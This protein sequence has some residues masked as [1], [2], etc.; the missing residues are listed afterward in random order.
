M[1]PVWLFFL[2]SQVSMW[3]TIVQNSY[4]T[5]VL[6]GWNKFRQVGRSQGVGSHDRV[7]SSSDAQAMLSADSTLANGTKSFSVTLESVGSQTIMATDTVATA[8]TGSS[9]SIEVST[10]TNL[11]GFHATG[12]MGTERAAHTATLLQNGK[13]LIAGGFNNTDV[14]ATAELFDPATGTFTPTGA[15][16]TPRFSHTAT[17]LANGKVLVTGGS[18]NLGDLATHNSR[19]VNLLANGKVLV[20]GGS[21]NSGDLATAEL[22]DPATGTFTATG[23]MSEPR[24]EHTATL[25]ANGTVL[26]AGGAAGNAAE[27]FDPAT[28]SFTAT[29]ELT[30]GGRWG[31]TATLLK[32]GT[33]LIAGGRDSEDV[34]DAFP[35][36]DAELFNPAT[37]TFTATG[38]MTQFRYEHAAALLN[39]GQVLLTA[40]AE[41]IVHRDI[42]PA[43]I[44]VT[45]RGHAKILDFGLAKVSLAG[46]SSSKVA[47]LNTQTGSV[48][49]E[50]LTSP[51]STLGT[52]AYMS[53]EQSHVA[54]RRST[55]LTPSLQVRCLFP[56]V[57][58]H[59][60][61]PDVSW[62]IQFDP[63][64]QR[65]LRIDIDNPSRSMLIRQ[66]DVNRDSHST[67]QPNC[68]CDQCSMKADDDGLAL[69]RPA[70][71]ASL[72]NRDNHL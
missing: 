2:L 61:A 64:V 67:T 37:G 56:V 43:N 63:A 22:F 42:K 47:S 34:F 17:L 51:G 55:S 1:G 23:A 69:A 33:V 60:H 3:Q 11:H 46:S 45:K 13:V 16:T 5:S 25:L 7:W 28:G 14:L 18:P 57:R 27:L 30:L 26:L 31:S 9:K 15:M 65:V 59:A 10:S 54:R 38:V 70:P 52:V 21:D 66:V 6:H 24:S 58:R 20:T 53:P 49:A 48:D 72:N 36:N 4:S 32:D 35:L 44:F 19:T 68:G 62:L 40:H 8:I 39:N 50:H 71:S 29:G 12:D 41:G